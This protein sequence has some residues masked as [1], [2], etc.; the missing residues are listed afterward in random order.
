MFWGWLRNDNF[1]FDRSL[2]LMPKVF[3]LGDIIYS[4][5]EENQNLN[6]HSSIV[7]VV[8]YFLFIYFLNWYLIQVRKE[9]SEEFNSLFGGH[10][11][12]EVDQRMA[13]FSSIEI[14]I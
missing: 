11:C 14:D 12:F 1:Q 7:V 8:F 3:N 9:N 13:I 4:F 5:Y 10:K 2:Y 6:P